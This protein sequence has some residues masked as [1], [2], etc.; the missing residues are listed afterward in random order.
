MGGDPAA[1]FPGVVHLIRFFRNLSVARKLAAS[2]VLA[3]SLLAALVAL[4]ALVVRQGGEAAQDQAAERRAM[5]AQAAAKAAAQEVLMANN[6]WRGVLLANCPD[7]LEQDSAQA[8]R[9]MEAAGTRLREAR[10]LADSEA[11]AQ[12]IAAA[13]AQAEAL[14]TIYRAGIAARA[15]LLTRRDRDFFPRLPEFD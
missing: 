5:A 11:A 6:G 15:E 12:G 3:L 8:I 14:G 2:S 10:G 13:V 4:V 9:A 7:A 1:T